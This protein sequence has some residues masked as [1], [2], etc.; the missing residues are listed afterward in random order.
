MDSAETRKKTT[1]AG[2]RNMIPWFSK[3]QLVTIFFNDP[4]FIW[5]DAYNHILME[6]TKD[7][8][9]QY[10]IRHQEVVMW[11]LKCWLFSVTFYRITILL[12]S[13]IYKR[14][15]ALQFSMMI[16]FS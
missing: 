6:T 2:N 7:I 9:N 4:G 11:D 10:K 14:L 3:R 15:L 5:D 12:G 8:I 1:S 13:H 16:K